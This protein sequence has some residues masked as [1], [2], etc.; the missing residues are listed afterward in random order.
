[1]DGGGHRARTIPIDTCLEK[2]KGRILGVSPP[3]E[4]VGAPYGAVVSPDKASTLEFAGAKIEIPAGAVDADVRVTMR[5]LD[6]ARVKPV[7]AEMD[8]VTAGGAGLR[9][10]P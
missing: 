8:N 5:A 1:M 9:F 10:G 2:P 3:L 4:D 7:E 6:P